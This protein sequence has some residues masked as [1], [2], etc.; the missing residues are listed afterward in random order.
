MLDKNG[1]FRARTTELT[2]QELQH[3]DELFK[4]HRKPSLVL[5]YLVGLS[6]TSF[7]E[8]LDNKIKEVIATL[9]ASLDAKIKKALAEQQK[10]CKK[11]GQ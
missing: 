4:E 11:K 10:K 1:D 3:L 6:M 9:E 7:D 2:T 8:K 5:K